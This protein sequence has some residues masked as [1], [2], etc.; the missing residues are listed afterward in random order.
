MAANIQKRGK[1]VTLRRHLF[2]RP[3]FYLFVRSSTHEVSP[4][5]AKAASSRLSKPRSHVASS[6]HLTGMK[7]LI[8]ADSAPVHRGGH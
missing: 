6:F 3:R 4:S 2:I 8:M 7:A 1:T 5:G